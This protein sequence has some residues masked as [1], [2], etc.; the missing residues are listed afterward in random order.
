MMPLG[1]VLLSAPAGLGSVI[2]ADIRQRGGGI[3]PNFPLASIATEQGV[4][5]ISSFYDL[6][7]WL[8]TP[9][10]QG[11]VAQININRAVLTTDPNNINPALFT[12]TE[13][14]QIVQSQITP[15]IDFNIVYVDM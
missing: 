12:A 5:L 4:Q 8:G 9:V 1:N 15:G 7:L 13:I 14:N 3:P 10:T 2:V 6:G 11:G